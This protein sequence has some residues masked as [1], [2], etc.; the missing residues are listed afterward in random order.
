MVLYRFLWSVL[1]PHSSPKIMAWALSNPA[2]PLIIVYVNTPYQLT[3]LP[4]PMRNRSPWINV[5]EIP[6]PLGDV[7][8]DIADMDSRSGLPLCHEASS[9]RDCIPSYSSVDVAS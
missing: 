9:A 3:F 5:T 8:G 7:K 2:L 4:A 6:Q 1:K